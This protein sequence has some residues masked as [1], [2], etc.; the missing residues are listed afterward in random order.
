MSGASVTPKSQGGAF[1][2]DAETQ[3]SPT[4]NIVLD[5][6]TT[7]ETALDIPFQVNQVQSGSPSAGF[8]GINIDIDKV[9][10]RLLENYFLYFT[11]NGVRWFSVDE[12]GGIDSLIGSIQLNNK[13]NLSQT[14]MIVANG[15]RIDYA[16]TS[17]VN[18]TVQGD[19]QT[20][21]D[22][23]GLKVR[24]TRGTLALGNVNYLNVDAQ[25][26]HSSVAGYNGIKITIDEVTTGSGDKN[27][28]NATVNG[29][30]KFNVTNEGA[31]TV[32]DLE[33]AEP[34]TVAALPSGV[35]G[36]VARI[37]DGDAALAWGDVAI[38]SGAGATSYMVWFN[39]TN[40]TIL[41]K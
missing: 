19:I 3:I 14:R 7:R 33:L 26:N 31:T 8:T 6:T 28:I 5:S 24:T 17:T 13:I 11:V 36:Q 16:G 37:T 20:S 23:G 27:L 30:E 25:V 22:N 40:W 10:A 18:A 4:E 12:R 29:A 1:V 38:N 39:G 35:T 9:N 34:Y 15:R 41:G 2:A 21:R 32:K